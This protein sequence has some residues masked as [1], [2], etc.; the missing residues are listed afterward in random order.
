MAG[1]SG[2]Q[3]SGVI[4]ALL[5][6]GAWGII[7]LYWR[8]LGEVPPVEL[9]AFRVV[10]SVGFV[11]AYLALTGAWPQLKRTLTDPRQL[12]LLF[13]S[14]LL[15]GANWG[16]FIAAIQWHR[17]ADAS[18]GYFLNP[19]LNVALGVLVL[20]ETL[21]P[22]QKWAVAL[23]SVAMAMMILFGGGLPLIALFLAGSF[24]IYGLVRK[25]VPVP[26]TVGLMVETLLLLPIALGYLLWLGPESSA[27]YGAGPLRWFLAALSGPVTALPLAWFAVAARS[28]PLSTLGLTQYLAPTGQFLLAVLAFGETMPP[29]KWAAFALIWV[30]LA[31]FSYDLLRTQRR[32]QP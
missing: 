23:A 27:V 22:L 31:L 19:L 11:A 16:I 30:A 29:F 2:A 9:L 1:V 12:R 25:S 24:A 7:P 26:A 3:R 21:R 17:L 5:A 10:C 20:K 18:L 32:V 13:L 4:S 8:L 28:L 14:G 6:Y 15:I